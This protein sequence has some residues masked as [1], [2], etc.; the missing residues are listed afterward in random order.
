M[1]KLLYDGVYIP[2]F[3]KHSTDFIFYAVDRT[4]N[5]IVEGEDVIRL[6]TINVFI[7]SI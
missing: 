3:I 2:L 5:K 1:S 7:G 6:S 4:T